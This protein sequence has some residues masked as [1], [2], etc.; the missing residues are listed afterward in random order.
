[1]PTNLI[2]RNHVRMRMRIVTTRLHGRAIEAGRGVATKLGFDVTYDTPQGQKSHECGAIA[3]LT[4]HRALNRDFDALLHADV[5]AHL[6]TTALDAAYAAVKEITAAQDD[7]HQIEWPQ[8][9]VGV[10]DQYPDLKDGHIDYL[11]ERLDPN[12]RR[13]YVKPY[14][15]GLREIAFYYARARFYYA[16]ARF[17]D[18]GPTAEIFISNDTVAEIGRRGSH[19]FTVAMASVFSGPL[20]ERKYIDDLD[21]DDDFD[22][23]AWKKKLET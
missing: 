10:G 16:H 2:S 18:L 17:G 11:L 7:E 23:D 9:L 22:Q 19:Y 21:S 13:S 8:P 15:H 20:Q 5:T 3:A 1:M 4:V 12:D 6:D 14:D